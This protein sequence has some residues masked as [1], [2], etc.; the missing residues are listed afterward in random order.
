MATSG[1]ITA[2]N[3]GN[4]TVRASSGS[5]ATADTS[6][7][8]MPV[9]VTV[10]ITG[11]PFTYN[12]NPHAATVTTTP[13]IAGYS[14]N[15]AGATTTYNSSTPPKN[16][17]TYAVTV[18]ITDPNYV[19]SGSGTGSITIN[20]ATPTVAVSFAA[21]PI[22]YDGNPHPAAA[23]VTG[24]KSIVLGA[25]DGTVTISYKKGGVAFAGTPTDAASYTAS[26]H[27]ASSN[28]NYNDADS[29]VDAALVINKAT[30]VVKIFNGQTDVTNATATF[31]YSG[32]PQGLTATVTGVGNDQLAISS[33]TYDGS[34]TAPTNVKLV[35]NVVSGY[36]V[37]ATFNATQ[38]YSS[39]KASAAEEIT[40]ATPTVKIF[41]GP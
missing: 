24:V 5:L 21:S 16:A 33:I 26:A 12:G 28:S 37:V 39:E 13:S 40:K 1:T 34:A 15:Y 22:P 18:T 4:V 30:P 27:F 11:G 32:S 3:V 7:T 31:T 23:T 35:A 41:D 36:A 6:F 8:V 14:V 19:L 10:S 29:T 25:S 2:V 38:N 17:D 9:P 20:R